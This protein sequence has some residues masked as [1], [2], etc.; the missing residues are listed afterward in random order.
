MRIHWLAAALLALALV[1]TD[2]TRLAAQAA[3]PTAEHIARIRAEA[4]SRRNARRVRVTLFD[5]TR[6][7]GRVVGVTDNDVTIQPT[8]SDEPVMFTYDK[9]ESIQGAPA[10]RWV[11]PVIAAGIVAGV[12]AVAAAAQ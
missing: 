1:A 10:P 7:A 5:G 12:I 2:E 4:A 11:V 8:P 9:I 6:A 3:A